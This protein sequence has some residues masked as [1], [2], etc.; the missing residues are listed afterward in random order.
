M[1]VGLVLGPLTGVGPLCRGLRDAHILKNYSLEPGTPGI[2]RSIL[3]PRRSVG[4]AN[5]APQNFSIG[6]V[7]FNGGS[8]NLLQ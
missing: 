2:S 3:C 8:L 5:Q 6:A 1:T 7:E 4:S